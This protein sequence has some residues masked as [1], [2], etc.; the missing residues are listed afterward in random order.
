MSTIF[1]SQFVDFY[2]LEIPLSETICILEY[3]ECFELILGC[4]AQYFLLL[5]L[6]IFNEVFF[7]IQRT[8]SHLLCYW[9]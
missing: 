2:K 5:L 7:I 4:F 3:L 9:L 1:F 6:Q 8:K